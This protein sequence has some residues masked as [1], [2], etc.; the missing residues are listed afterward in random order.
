MSQR[1]PLTDQ[2]QTHLKFAG[3]APTTLEELA[4]AKADYEHRRRLAEI[5]AIRTKLA[6]LEEF[7]PALAQRGIQL[8]HRDISTWDHGKT[9]RIQAPV[10]ERDGKLLQVLLELGF[11]EI[12]RKSYGSR[13]E[14][15][16]LKHGRSLLVAIDVM[17]VQQEAAVPA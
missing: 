5:K 14:Q 16:T 15:V 9:L 12:E 8:Q 11:R 2:W 13:D 4:I 1:A 17:K 10:L 7:L 3:R 6:L